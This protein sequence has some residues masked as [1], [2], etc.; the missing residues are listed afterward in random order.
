MQTIQNA[1]T[2]LDEA[3]EGS[4]ENRYLVF[5]L[6]EQNYALEISGISEIIKMLPITKVPGIPGCIKGIINLRGTIT[7][8]M[9]MRLR[10]GFEEAAYHDRTCIIILNKHDASLGLIVDDVQEVLT[11]PKDKIALPSS[12]KGHSAKTQFIR[13][14]GMVND[15]LQLLLDCDQIMDINR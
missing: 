10:F 15:K 6:K 2:G 4:T 3:L 7:P 8:V 12:E 14:V 13:G 1:V 5:S 11:I 9:D